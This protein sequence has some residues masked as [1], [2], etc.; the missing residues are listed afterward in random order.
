[1]ET[2][3]YQGRKIHRWVQGPSTFLADPVAG[4]RLISWFTEM[5]DGSVRDVIY[6]P[7]D[8]DYGDIGKVRGGNPILFPFAGRCHADGDT[9]CWEDQDGL[10]R[11][12]P[13]HGFARTSTFELMDANESSFKA[14]LLPDVTACEAYPYNYEFRVSYFFSELGFQVELGL[15][16]N[17]SF[18]IPWCPGHHFYFSLPWHYEL[19]R[20]CYEIHIPAKR[21][22]RHMEDGSLEREKVADKSGVFSF[23]E[24][25]LVNR[26]HTHLQDAECTFGPKGGEENVAIRFKNEEPVASSRALVTWT[27]SEEAPFYCIEPWMGPPN[28][29]VHRK[30]LQLVNPGESSA[31]A[32]EVSLV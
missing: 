25:V 3:E 19:G 5:A 10:I 26:I 1:M 20:D 27:E 15:R 9:D 29:P 23:D 7:E 6:W 30:G 11:P 24:P 14:V 8:A 12:M 22:L 28:S 13:Q 17:E 18:P 16:N 4:G 32:V 31:F 21:A 2:F